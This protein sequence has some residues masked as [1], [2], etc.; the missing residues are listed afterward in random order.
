M[1]FEDFDYVDIDYDQNT[2]TIIKEGHSYTYDISSEN[3]LYGQIMGSGGVDKYEV[4]SQED[5]YYVEESNRD[6]NE[7]ITELWNRLQGM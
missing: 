3:T 6:V 4:Y 1:T 7:E 5:E 2:F